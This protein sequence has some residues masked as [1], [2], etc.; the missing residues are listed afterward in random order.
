MLWRLL[1]QAQSSDR[2]EDAGDFAM[3]YPTGYYRD[4]ADPPVILLAR[5]ILADRRNSKDAVS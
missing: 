1:R 5:R 4:I 2:E 3:F